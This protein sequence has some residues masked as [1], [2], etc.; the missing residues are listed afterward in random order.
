MQN[1]L[2]AAGPLSTARGSGVIPALAVNGLHDRCDGAFAFGHLFRI[3]VQGL[4]I[5]VVFNPGEPHIGHADLF[6][7]IDERRPLQNVRQGGQ[8]LGRMCAVGPVIA[9]PGPES[10]SISSN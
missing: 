1:T 6:T 4:N 9:E 2:M 3:P 10:M 5:P 7:L 8:H